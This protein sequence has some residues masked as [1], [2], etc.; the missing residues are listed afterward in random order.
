MASGEWSPNDWFLV[1][2]GLL[3]SLAYCSALWVPIC[4]ATYVLGRKRFGLPSLFV[5]LTAECVALADYGL[6]SSL[7]R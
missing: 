1:L 3:T 7:W 2:L 4:Y 5:F 6:D